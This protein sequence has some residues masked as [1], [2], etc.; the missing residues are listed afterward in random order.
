MRLSFPH[1]METYSAKLK[2]M[3][4]QERACNVET[5]THLSLLV[6]S[7]LTLVLLCKQVLDYSWRL[8]VSLNTC[9]Y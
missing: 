8:Q 9:S 6:T 7:V 1:A 5:I 3:S 4:N 2:A